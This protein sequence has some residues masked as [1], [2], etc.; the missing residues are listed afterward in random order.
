MSPARAI[1]LVGL[2]VAAAMPPAR[3]APPAAG[4]VEATPHFFVLRSRA[5][6]EEVL[7]SLQEAVKRKNYVVTGVNDMDDTLA[8]RAVEIGAAPL[9]YERYKIVGFCNLTLADQ[10]LRISPDVG[11]FFPC[12]AVVFKAR[13]AAETTVVAFRPM[14]LAPALDRPGMEAI[15]RQ[16]EAD[17]LEILAEVAAD[18]PQ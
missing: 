16:A 17:V 5:P 15:L 13:G 9:P 6:F 2:V 7:T 18:S 1:L 10:G 14:F 11:V 12:R 4:R 3:A 8:R